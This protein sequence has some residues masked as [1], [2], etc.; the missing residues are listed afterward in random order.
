M[1]LA[2]SKRGVVPARMLCHCLI[3]FILLALA[4]APASARILKTMKSAFAAREHLTIGSGLEYQ[5]DSEESETDFP[6]LLEYGFTEKLK[7][8]VEPN[9]ARIHRK[10]EASVSGFGELETAV[11]YDFLAERR[12]RPGLSTEAIV[13]WPTAS[14]DELG[15]GKADYSLG[16][17]ASMAFVRAD[18][19]FNALYTFVG[20]PP[21]ADLKNTIEVSLACEYRLTR[22][23]ALE[24]ELGAVFGSGGRFRATGGLGNRG[25]VIGAS[26][27][28]GNEIS[29]TLGVAENMNEYLKLEEGMIVYTDGSWQAV[30]AWEW[31]FAGLD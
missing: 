15:T 18:M 19:D 17:V 30:L 2:A 11:T 26:D 25:G 20:N 10:A 1:I 23:I 6:F 5:T 28:G 3:V 14:P 29:A 12:Y 16:L 22:A 9:W 31:A 8:T 27:E 13:K 7:L 21:G 24:G 4:S